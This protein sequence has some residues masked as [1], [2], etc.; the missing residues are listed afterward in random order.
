MSLNAIIGATIILPLIGGLVGFV[1][2]RKSAIIAIGSVALSFLGA[3]ALLAFTAEPIIYRW[4]WLPG[5]LLG[6]L[7]DK[8]SMLMIAL[9]TFI[10]LLVFIFSSG[11]M[12]DDE[13]IHQPK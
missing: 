5:F 3:L 12:H 13:G 4:E 7:V 1:S 11:Y 10:S 2:P 6:I 8:I 9:V